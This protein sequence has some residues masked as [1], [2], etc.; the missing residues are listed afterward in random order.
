MRIAWFRTTA[1]DASNPLDDTAALIDELREAHVIDVVREAEAHDFVWR[2]FLKPWD[3]CV[4]ELE[5]TAKHQFEWGYLLNYPGIVFLK[6]PDVENSCGGT[7]SRE[8]RLDD[9]MTGFRLDAREQA[10]LRVP[11]LASR[12]VV[13]PYESLAESLQESYPDARVRYTPTG[14]RRFR[15]P[16]QSRAPTNASGGS[17]RTVFG[18]LNAG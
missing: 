14:V 13:V 5:N 10:P 1:P 2:H 8:G 6:S 16:S 4:Y 18:V 3:L 7:L 11:L 12:S 17:A 9:Y 15:S